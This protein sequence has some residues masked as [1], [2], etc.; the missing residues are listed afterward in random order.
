MWG[1]AR[2]LAGERK[3]LDAVLP[4][5]LSLTDAVLLGMMH[6]AQA[7]APSIAGL[8]PHAAVRFAAHVGAFDG[9]GSAAGNT[10][11]MP[12][13]PSAMSR[14]RSAVLIGPRWFANALR[15]EPR[16][17]RLLPVESARLPLLA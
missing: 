8:Q 17:E 4:F 3:Q 5:K 6:T 11:V 9:K 15:Q 14:A 16:H 13:H 2:K 1:F 12:T 10:A 7:D